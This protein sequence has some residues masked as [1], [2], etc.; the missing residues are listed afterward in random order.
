MRPFSVCLGTLPLLSSHKTLLE[1]F[2]V[3]SLFLWP[4]PAFPQSYALTLPRNLVQLVDESELIVQ[5]R[6]T[7][8]MLEPHAQLN[9]LLTIVVTLQVEETLKGTIV[10]TYTFRQ[11]VIDR[12]DQQQKMGYRAGQRLL[13]TLIRPSVYGL[14]SPAGMQQG[15]FSIV[16]G[17]DGKLH[18]TNGFGNA[19]LFRGL[20]TELPTYGTQ[21]SPEVRAMVAQANPGPIPLDDLKRL[22]RSLATRNSPQ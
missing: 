5:G 12:R 22:I 9:N 14:T 8:V 6:V 2:A 11:A 15:R 21:V 18:A 1:L 7:S 13:L 20:D 10:G 19:G 4:H 16:V 3:L 17:A